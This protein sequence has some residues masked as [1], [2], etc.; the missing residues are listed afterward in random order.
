MTSG[1]APIDVAIGSYSFLSQDVF[2]GKR[3]SNFNAGFEKFL[4]FLL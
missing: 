2:R 4:V 3:G 1:S